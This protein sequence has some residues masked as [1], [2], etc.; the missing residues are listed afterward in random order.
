MV[1]TTAICENVEAIY[2]I[3]KCIPKTEDNQIYKT[4]DICE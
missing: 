1:R 2:E 3:M 4:I